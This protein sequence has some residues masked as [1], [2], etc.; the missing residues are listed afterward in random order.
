M[1]VRIKT[2]KLDESCLPKVEKSGTEATEAESE[3]A[4]E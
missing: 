3:A 2:V 1:D 4:Q